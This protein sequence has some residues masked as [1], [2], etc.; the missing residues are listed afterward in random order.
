MNLRSRFAIRAGYATTAHHPCF[1]SDGDCSLFDENAEE[2][3]PRAV[4]RTNENI[5]KR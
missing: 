5:E 1:E 2:I 3:V 4:G